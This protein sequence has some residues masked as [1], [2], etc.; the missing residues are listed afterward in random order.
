MMSAFLTPKS[1]TLV[2]FHEGAVSG[3]RRDLFHQPQE[4]TEQKAAAALHTLTS[5]AI[6]ILADQTFPF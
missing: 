6:L 3:E 1:C 5:G 4:D 2:H